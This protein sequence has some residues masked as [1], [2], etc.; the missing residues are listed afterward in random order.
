M[1]ATSAGDGIW[2]QALGIGFWITEGGS[3]ISKF[4]ISGLITKLRMILQ[5]LGE[6]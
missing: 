4:P 2:F 6:D 5:G 1:E 3:S